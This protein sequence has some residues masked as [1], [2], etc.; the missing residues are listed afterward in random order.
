ME[1]MRQN[2]S[3][4]SHKVSRS[5]SRDVG[6][7]EPSDVIEIGSD[8]SDEEVQLTNIRGSSIQPN[9][10]VGI[11][12]DEDEDDEIQITGS[13]P[14]PLPLRVNPWGSTTNSTNS[15]ISANNSG[16]SA[17]TRVGRRSRREVAFSD[18]RRDDDIEITDVIPL[19]SPAQALTWV[20]TPIGTFGSALP[21]P[22]HPRRVD[23]G[24]H[25]FGY[26]VNPEH[27]RN[28]IGRASRFVSLGRT[29]GQVGFMDILRTVPFSLRGITQYDFPGSRFDLEEA[30]QSIMQRI[31]RDNEN[32][33][34][35][36]LAN[37]N[38]YNRK[39]LQEKKKVSKEELA[40]YVNDIKPES[41]LCCSLC[42]IILGEG[43]P[44]DFK[45]DH[46]YDLHFEKLAKQYRVQAPWFCV[47][48]CSKVDKELS[49]RIFIAK[50][51]HTF[52]GRCVKNIGNR[53]RRT[54][55]TPSG[56]TIDNPQLSSPTKCGAGDCGRK[57]TAKG[58]TELYF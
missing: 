17:A 49:K 8:D 55:A 40:G 52:C 18:R 25:T 19:A 32:A 47:K 36:R 29:D 48:Q 57:F 42:G 44:E 10:V 2:E 51:G 43:I 21:R 11:D 3:D 24:H 7:S 38:I 15:A 5:A 6:S 9:E 14:N 12:D 39:T 45:S 22:V 26:Y 35:A 37:E 58:F 53:A 27:S 56:F 4:A 50:C 33:L 16:N 1:A 31:E 46:R 28:R 13:N 30:E 23:P 54:K 20:E 34:D 41:N